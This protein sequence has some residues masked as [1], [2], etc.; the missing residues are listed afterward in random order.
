[1]ACQNGNKRIAK[2]V[3]T[4]GTAGE[5]VRSEPGGFARLP[6]QVTH[7]CEWTPGDQTSDISAFHGGPKRVQKIENQQ[8]V[9]IGRMRI[10]WVRHATCNTKKGTDQVTR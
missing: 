2:L 9:A 5:L 8:P 10:H 7:A 4:L 3:G 6:K 1:M